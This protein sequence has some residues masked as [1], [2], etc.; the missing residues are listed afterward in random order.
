MGISRPALSNLAGI[1]L[2]SVLTPVA[3]VRPAADYRRDSSERLQYSLMES[4]AQRSMTPEEG[5]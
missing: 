5:R 4:F 3:T 1:F 2:C